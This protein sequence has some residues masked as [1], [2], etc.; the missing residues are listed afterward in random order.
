M[1]ERLTGEGNTPPIPPELEPLQ[2][3]S[4]SDYLNRLKT[5]T[6][7]DGMQHA[8]LDGYA[9][10]K[11]LSIIGHNQK[12]AR[13][14]Q[15]INEAEFSAEEFLAERVSF[16]QNPDLINASLRAINVA[17]AALSRVGRTE[18]EEEHRRR[19]Q[20][21]PFKAME[22]IFGKDI[23]DRGQA[24]SRRRME[25]RYGREKNTELIT[26]EELAQIALT[27]RESF[28]PVAVDK[29][30]IKMTIN[31]FAKYGIDEGV[32]RRYT[33]LKIKEE[34]HERHS[35]NKEISSEES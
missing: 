8:L 15:H 29:I 25:D 19:R 24:L 31:L 10:L 33:M 12:I 2:E 20:S 32:A 11:D 34:I 22:A 1:T 26:S 6:Y 17:T 3:E 28:D 27:L 14:S 23:V 18:I 30:A 9:A 35:D 16:T 5:T 7:T 21:K 13:Y 4:S